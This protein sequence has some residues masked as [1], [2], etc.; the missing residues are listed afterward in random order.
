MVESHA[1]AISLFGSQPKYRP[2]RQPFGAIATSLMSDRRSGV[3]TEEADGFWSAPP[4]RL[5]GA[6]QADATAI[7][8][9][10]TVMVPFRDGAGGGAHAA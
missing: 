2:S 10:R 6:A 9:S 4:L 5:G 8:A 7:G 3:A 1:M